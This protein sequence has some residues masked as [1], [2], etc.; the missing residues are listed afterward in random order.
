MTY[1]IK[2]H[3]GLSLIFLISVSLYGI[4]YC[5][6]DSMASN[7]VEE[8]K[9]NSDADIS[10]N[11]NPENLPSMSLDGTALNQ[12][13]PVPES[14]NPEK[15]EKTKKENNKENKAKSKISKDNNK[16]TPKTIPNENNSKEN[17]TI[18]PRM[19]PVKWIYG[20]TGTG[21]D[22]K[23]SNPKASRHSSGKQEHEPVRDNMNR[24]ICSCGHSIC[25]WEA[26]MNDIKHSQG[27]LC[28]PVIVWDEAR[29]VHPEPLPTPVIVNPQKDYNGHKIV[30]DAKQ[31]RHI[32]SCGHVICTEGK[33]FNEK[34]QGK[35]NCCPIL[36][37]TEG[38]DFSA[39]I[40]PSSD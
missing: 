5:R 3:I 28:C 14:P 19:T 18:I 20:I 31:K 13:L 38:Y 21:S 8:N 34:R 11:S 12:L 9:D 25:T 40:S 17:K 23:S 15:L 33:R 2:T 35:G 29:G 1:M 10:Q 7:T 30:W 39:K 26:R 37:W 27:T 32:C 4:S 16:K 36:V 22:Q 6:A 24:L